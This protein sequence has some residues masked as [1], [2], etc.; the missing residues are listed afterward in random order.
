MRRLLAVLLFTS[1]W[2]NNAYAA[3]EKGFARIDDLAVRAIIVYAVQPEYPREARLHHITG[4]GVVIM[5]VDR[6][7]GSVYSCKM[8][9]ST[10]SD[11]LDQAALRAFRQWRFKP[12]TAEGVRVPVTFTMPDESD[13][14]LSDYHVK[15]KSMDDA[16]AGFL[17]KGMVANGP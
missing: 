13:Q 2:A 5:W 15:E 14:F 7:T 1:L 4:S 3:K 9:Q 8:L 6:A 11:I 17:G 10:G 16:L 12:G